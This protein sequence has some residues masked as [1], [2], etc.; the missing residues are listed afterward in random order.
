M[1]EQL[2]RRQLFVARHFIHLKM[3]RRRL[4]PEPVILLKLGIV[5]H[6]QHARPT[7]YGILYVS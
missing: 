6:K 4:S 3:E 2:P 5:G 1:Q 7:V